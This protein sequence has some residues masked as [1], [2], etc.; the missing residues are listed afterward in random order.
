MRPMKIKV[1]T[2]G[3]DTLAWY[4]TSRGNL[5]VNRNLFNDMSDVEQ[6]RILLDAYNRWF[7]DELAREIRKAELRKWE[8]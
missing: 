6:Q 5:V 8:R 2:L 4:Y 1:K 7:T 3:R